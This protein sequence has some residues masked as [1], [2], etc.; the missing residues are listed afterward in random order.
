MCQRVEQSL[1]LPLLPLKDNWSRRLS[2]RSRSRLEEKD[3]LGSDVLGPV[4]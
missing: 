1:G 3:L 2:G 4:M